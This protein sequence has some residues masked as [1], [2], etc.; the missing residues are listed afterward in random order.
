[1]GLTSPYRF[2]YV[3][4]AARALQSHDLSGKG[5]NLWITHIPF[6]PYKD[7]ESLPGW[8]ITPPPMPG[9]LP[10][11]HKHEIRYTPGI[12]SVIPTRRIWNDYCGQ[13]IFEDLGGLK[14]PHIIVLQVR[15]TSP[16]K[17]VPTRGRT[18]V[19]CVIS[20]HATACSTAVDCDNSYRKIIILF[21]FYGE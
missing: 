10:R 15:K 3:A 7:M 2:L 13:M 1:M 4:H 20:A 17:P 18:R 6:W 8:V 5:L 11:Q 16:R 12:H 14:F 21:L 9:Q 19:H